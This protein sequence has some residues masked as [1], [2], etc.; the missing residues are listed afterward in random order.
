M[1]KCPHACKAPR[2]SVNSRFASRACFSKS[3]RTA[4]Y[5]ANR[6][7]FLLVNRLIF[8]VAPGA[9]GV[10]R[11]SPQR[12][13]LGTRGG[14]VLAPT[15]ATLSCDLLFEPCRNFGLTRVRLTG[16]KTWTFPMLAKVA[17]RSGRCFLCISIHQQGA[18]RSWEGPTPD[19]SK[20]RRTGPALPPGSFKKVTLPGA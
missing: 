7:A 8:R 12:V 6:S 1:K 2:L 3:P 9:A 15:S 10:E 19:E 11:A 20:T 13:S 5:V 16:E 17:I 4:K 18:I 14:A